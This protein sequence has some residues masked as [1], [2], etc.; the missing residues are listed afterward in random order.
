LAPP[1]RFQ[2]AP[3][4]AKTGDEFLNPASVLIGVPLAVIVA[5]VCYTMGWIVEMAWRDVTVNENRRFRIITFYSGL[6]FSALLMSF[7]VWIAL[8]NWSR[9]L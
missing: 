3:G 2:E 6:A 1:I 7:P 4:Y 8:L 5:N 9:T